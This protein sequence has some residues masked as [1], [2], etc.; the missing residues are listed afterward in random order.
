MKQSRGV[1]QWCEAILVSFTSFKIDMSHVNVLLYDV[2]VRE[3]D[4]FARFGDRSSLT[5]HVVDA[6][7]RGGASAVTQVYLE[8][9]DK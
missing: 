5:L 1:G 7:H 3:S 4:Q 6:Y 2:Y 9:K 8:Y